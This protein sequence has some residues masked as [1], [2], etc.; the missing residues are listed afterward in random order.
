MKTDLLLHFF[1]NFNKNAKFRARILESN[2]FIYNHGYLIN[3]YY[4][5]IFK[6]TSNVIRNVPISLLFF[7]KKSFKNNILCHINFDDSSPIL[8]PITKFKMIY[9]NYYVR[10]MFC[11]FGGRKKEGNRC[12][13]RNDSN[14]R[15]VANTP[16]TISSH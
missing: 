3:L 13:I 14:G 2:C 12:A 4:K 10:V 15:F 8:G 7:M 5:I 1:S 9:H 16:I 6:L 11:R